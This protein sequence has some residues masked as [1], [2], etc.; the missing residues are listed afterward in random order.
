M[1]DDFDRCIQCNAQLQRVPNLDSNALTCIEIRQGAKDAARGSY[2]TIMWSTR[3]MSQRRMD[4]FARTCVP[5]LDEL[6][7]ARMR[8]A[9]NDATGTFGFLVVDTK[10]R[11]LSFYR[12]TP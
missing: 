10:S 5:W 4:E 12:T 2:A 8:E 1:Y 6:A 3:E 11:T 7:L 9:I